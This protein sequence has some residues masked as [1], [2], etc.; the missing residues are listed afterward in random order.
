MLYLLKEWNKKQL[1]KVPI[2]CDPGENSLLN[3]S[4]KENTLIIDEEHWWEMIL[5][6][7][8]ISRCGYEGENEL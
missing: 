7:V 5:T 4:K 3:R 2:I 8:A 1:G 6:Q